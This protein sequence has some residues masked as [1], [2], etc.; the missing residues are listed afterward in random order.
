MARGDD[1]DLSA[2]R[3]GGGNRPQRPAAEE[4]T[5]YRRSAAHRSLKPAVTVCGF[6]HRDVEIVR[7][8]LARSDAC[9]G[10]T[11]LQPLDRQFRTLHRRR[12]DRRVGDADRV[13]Q[14]FAAEEVVG[15]DGL[16]LLAQR[17]VEVRERNLLAVAGDRIEQPGRIDLA[18]AHLVAVVGQRQ[19]HG[20]V[21]AD[22]GDVAVVV[23]QAGHVGVDRRGGLVEQCLELVG[24]EVAAELCG[25][26]E[27]ERATPETWGQAIEVPSM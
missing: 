24:R 21:Q 1:A 8:A 4:H 6:T 26:R 2:E 13:G 12:G 20:L 5:C 16:H 27:P 14:R 23:F 9:P 15:R 22:V 7:L 25:V 19:L 17:D 18:R 3:C 10:R 11:G